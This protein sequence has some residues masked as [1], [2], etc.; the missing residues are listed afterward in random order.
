MF[1]RQKFSLRRLLHFDTAL[2]LRPQFIYFFGLLLAVVVCLKKIAGKSKD[3]N[4]GEVED[5][6]GKFMDLVAGPAM[7][8][9]T[10]RFSLSL[11]PSLCISALLRCGFFQFNR[12]FNSHNILVCLK[13]STL[14]VR[15]YIF[16]CPQSWISI[17]LFICLL[18]CKLFFILWDE[19][20]FFLW[21]FI[22]QNL[23]SGIDS[24]KALKLNQ[25]RG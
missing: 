23:Y 11:V 2:I 5:V 15:W 14:H 6:V 12:Y 10:D 8:T 4:C 17:P 13:I 25:G 1:V 24:T 7:I 16:F 3:M 9:N 21:E 18:Q 22:R 20:P 19:L